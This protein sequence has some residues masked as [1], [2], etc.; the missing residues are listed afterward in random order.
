MQLGKGRADVPT[1]PRPGRGSGPACEDS[2]PKSS[3]ACGVSRLHGGDPSEAQRHHSP[4]CAHDRGAEAGGG[5]RC[6]CPGHP[7]SPRSFCRGEARSSQLGVQWGLQPFPPPP[8]PSPNDTGTATCQRWVTQWWVTRNGHCAHGEM[9]LSALCAVCACTW[10]CV[11]A[12]V[13]QCVSVCRSL[14][15]PSR[16]LV[17]TWAFTRMDVCVCVCVR[18]CVCVRSVWGRVPVSTHACLHAW[19]CAHMSVYTAGCMH[20][21]VCTHLC[22]SVGMSCG[23]LQERRV[24]TGTFTRV[25]ALA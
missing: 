4:R 14:W 12:R 1:P 7:S 18:T 15:V 8:Q 9:F 22:V 16:V 2:A 3:P 11:C 25:E 6:R 21:F 24:H 23:C 5:L 17:H 19:I 20:V 10:G 13:H